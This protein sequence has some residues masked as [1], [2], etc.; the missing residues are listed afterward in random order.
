MIFIDFRP[1][2]YHK[3]KCSYVAYYVRNPE[4]DELVRKRIK[5]N[6]VQGARNRDRFATRLCAEI[7]QKLYEG[8]NPFL[9]NDAFFRGTTLQ[10]GIKDFLASKGPNVRPDTVR[11][12]HSYLKWF[13]T[14][15]QNGGKLQLPIKLFSMHDAGKVMDALAA[16]LDIGAATYNSYLEFF[17]NLFNH[18]VTRDWIKENPFSKMPRRREE[19]KF[20]DLIPPH[21]R[22]RIADYFIQNDQIPY[23]Y[24]MQLC[25]RCLIRPKEMLMLKIKDIDFVEGLI[26]I[27]SDVAK[28][29]KARTIA[30]PKEI[31]AYLEKLEVYNPDDYIFSDDYLPG[32]TL[33]SSKDTARTWAK[34]RTAL[35]LPLKYQFY[36]L[37]DTGITEMLEGGVPA[38]FVKELADHSSLEVTERYMHKSEAKIILKFNKLEFSAKPTGTHY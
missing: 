5:L 22:Q 34:M 33:K 10:K 21:I 16:R 1:A 18:F 35:K 38:K 28:N 27:P 11:S 17:R 13:N 29:G 15:L 12:Y 30:V 25:Y 2:E 20:R 31:M 32:T 4:T 23:L 24:I 6:R 14:L 36:S 37:K 9:D 7:N 8:W 26:N 3:A 19:E